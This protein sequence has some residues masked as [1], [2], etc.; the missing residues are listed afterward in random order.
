M[1]A[2]PVLS[3]AATIKENERAASRALRKK[4]HPLATKLETALGRLDDRLAWAIPTST[5]GAWFKLTQGPGLYRLRRRRERRGGAD[6]RA[7]IATRVRRGQL[8]S[9]DLAWLRYIAD[10]LRD[11][12]TAA[13]AATFI[14]SALEWLA[15]PKSV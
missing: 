15:R 14:D 3:L 2:D 11:E 9:I 13:P 4:D 7:R 12:M 10:G 1:L 6:A 5:E 8:R